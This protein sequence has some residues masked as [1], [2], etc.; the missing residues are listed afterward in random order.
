MKLVYLDNSATTKPCDEAISA[1]NSCLSD[2]WGNPSSTYSLG[3]DSA[4]VLENSR[5][6]IADFI[7]AK[8]SEIYFTSGGTEANN[9]ALFGAAYQNRHKGNKIVASAIEHPSVLEPLIQLSQKGFEVVLLNPDQNGNIRVEDL[10]K[11]ID[12]KTILVSL[13]LVN[14]EVGSILPVLEASRVIK[15]KGSPALL[16]CDAVQAFGKLPIKVSALGVDLLSASGHKI[17]ASKGVGFLYKSSSLHIPPIVFGGGQESG[18]RS[19]TE[20]MPLIAG[21]AAAVKALDLKKTEKKMTELSQYARKKLSEFDFISFNSPEN[22]LPY[23]LNISVNGYK[24]EPMLNALGAKNIFVS[25]G[26]A[27]AKGHRSHVLGSMGFSSNRIDSALR[28]SFSRDNTCEDI[29]ILCEAIKE[30]TGKMRRFK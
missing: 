21:F 28:I 8:E 27:C 11:E 9:I 24:S 12:S 7:G 29:D 15:E 19:G 18:L 2:T 20:G 16:H 22:C 23:I 14:N 13:M 3:V 5:K 6:C 4:T 30:I 17:H 1:I 25:K 26:S 10:K